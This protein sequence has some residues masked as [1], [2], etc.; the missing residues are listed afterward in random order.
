MQPLDPNQIPKVNNAPSAEPPV[1]VQQRPVTYRD[2]FADIPRSSKDYVDFLEVKDDL[3]DE[4]VATFEELY[5]DYTPN[6]NDYRFLLNKGYGTPEERMQR[7]TAINKAESLEHIGNLF[8]DPS[9][10]VKDL[11]QHMQDKFSFQYDPAEGPS[12][13]NLKQI[14]QIYLANVLGK[15]L[16]EVNRDLL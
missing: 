14:N 9:K 13:E 4:Q 12:E 6:A 1:V 15:S 8:L 5:R 2:D 16:D 3:T 7:Q 11:P 10:L